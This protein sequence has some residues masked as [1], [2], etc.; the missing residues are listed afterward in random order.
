M[1]HFTYYQPPPLWDISLGAA[2]PLERISAMIAAQS[3]SP[4]FLGARHASRCPCS[5]RSSARS[6][7]LS[8]SPGRRRIASSFPSERRSLGKLGGNGVGRISCCSSSGDTP[9][10]ALRKILESPG[11]HQGPACFDALSA[12]LVERAGF[13]FCFTSGRCLIRVSLGF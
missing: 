1:L 10:K 9:A 11:I 4:N 2:G 12:K 3:G 8:S 5:R 6:L 7:P 13:R